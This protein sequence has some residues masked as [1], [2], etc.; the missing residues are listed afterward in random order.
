MRA[1]AILLLAVTT[2]CASSVRHEAPS[3]A[4]AQ[5]E[6]AVVEAPSVEMEFAA[7]ELPMPV[8]PEAGAPAK[9]H[10]PAAKSARP[11]PEATVKLAPPLPPSEAAA[12]IPD[13]PKVAVKPTHALDVA[14]LKAR[15]RDTHAIG[16]LTK[17]ALRNQMDDLI[18]RF[19]AYYDSGLK[20]GV[21]FLR[22]PYDAL[23][24]KVTTVLQEGDPSLAHSIAESRE[25]IWEI[26]ADPVQFDSST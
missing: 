5:G 2:G 10:S 19:R 26:L 7:V 13:L 1:I 20:T 23:L 12:A 14:D 3:Q 22:P 4:S 16:V 17:L 25:A 6:E 21:A 9:T 18:K 24:L 15:L 8:V 11:L